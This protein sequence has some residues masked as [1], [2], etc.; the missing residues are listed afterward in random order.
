MIGFDFEGI[1]FQFYPEILKYTVMA[2]VI[3]QG[4]VSAYKNKPT[5]WEF[6]NHAISQNRN[7]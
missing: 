7:I 1:I 4:D 5:K 3:Y 2:R 6:S